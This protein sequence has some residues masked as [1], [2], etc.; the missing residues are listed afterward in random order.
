MVDE[1]DKSSDNQRFL[2][3]LALLRTKYLFAAQGKE[4]TFHSVILAGV[5]DVKSLKLKVRSSEKVQYNSPWNIAVDFK[6]EMSLSPAEIET[7]LAEYAAE[8]GVVMPQ[9][10]LAQR[11]YDYTSGHPFLVS[12]LCKVIDEDLMHTPLWQPDFVEEAV[13]RILQLN[14]PNF[15]SLI[16]NL[17]NHPDL[18]E[19]VKK[20]FS[21]AKLSAT[22]VTTLSSIWGFFM[23]FLSSAIILWIF[24]IEFIKSKFTIT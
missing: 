5:H 7:M 16:K 11:L 8:T 9:P 2:D 17:E 23:E 19:L 12:K 4:A 6:V 20:S 14:H 1:V 13:S 3:F 15:E 10:V 22:I 24:I 18:Y 21:L